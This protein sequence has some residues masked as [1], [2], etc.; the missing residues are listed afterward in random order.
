MGRLDPNGSGR[1]TVDYNT[2][3]SI[4]MTGSFALVANLPQMEIVLDA[5]S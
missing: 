2:Y 5:P 3:V 1:I 4:A